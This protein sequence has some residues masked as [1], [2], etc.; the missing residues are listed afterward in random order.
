[1][2]SVFVG[3]VVTCSCGQSQPTFS[4]KELAQADWRRS[5]VTATD[6]SAATLNH[7]MK[8]GG[9]SGWNT[10]D[11]KARSHGVV[12]V[13]VAID[14]VV[15]VA[16]RLASPAPIVVDVDDFAVADAAA[17]EDVAPMPLFPVVVNLV[18]VWLAGGAATLIALPVLVIAR[19]VSAG[20]A[21]LPLCN[22]DHLLISL[23]LSRPRDLARR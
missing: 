13:A 11:Q 10:I 4:S 18:Q 15:A 19:E 6:E 21:W 8:G 3:I 12:A 22:A 7:A 1:M 9:R 20:K 14:I 5:R 23:R 16:R 2:R 17:E